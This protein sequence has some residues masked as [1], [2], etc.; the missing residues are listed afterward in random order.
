MLLV[1]FGQ[2]VPYMPSL[3]P[4]SDQSGSLCSVKVLSIR[5]TVVP[6]AQVHR[7]DL[8]GKNQAPVMFERRRICKLGRLYARI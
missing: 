5:T 1:C 8:S 7:D 3:S 4:S 2:A 6:I